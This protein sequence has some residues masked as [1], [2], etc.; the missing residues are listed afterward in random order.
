LKSFSV[1]TENRKNMIIMADYIDKEA[2]LSL[3]QPDAPKV[4]PVVHGRWVHT[5][6]ASHWYGKDE[7]SACTYHEND[8]S[9]LSHFNYC[10][11]CGAKM[12][13]WVIE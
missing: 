3:V 7:C 4:V 12:D 1:T 10:P 8:R 11:N 2:A 13:G 6:L 9:D 5:D